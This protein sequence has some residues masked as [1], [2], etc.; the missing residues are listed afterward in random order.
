MQTFLPH[1]SFRNSAKTLDN[2]RLNKQIT[3]C[4]QIYN[5]LTGASNGWRNHP[6][7]KMWKSHEHALTH[8]GE[9]MY[10][11]WIYRYEE[12]L[13]SGNRQHKAGE[14][15]ILS[16]HYSEAASLYALGYEIKMPAWLGDVRLHASHR[17]NLLRK[18]ALYYA[19]FN[20]SEPDN[21]PYFWPT[22]EGY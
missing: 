12:G 10:F 21:L 16:K 15:I 22:K 9:A 2:K 5:T 18:D 1:E 4:M 13:R 8:Y 19:Q 11:E 17:S 3:E 14:K 20:W 7:V 6:A